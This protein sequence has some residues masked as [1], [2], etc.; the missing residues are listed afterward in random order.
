MQA[1]ATPM[2]V[3]MEGSRHADETK[4]LALSANP[5][6]RLWLSQ[7][8]RGIQLRLSQGVL[9]PG[10]E[11][12]RCPCATALLLPVSWRIPEFPWTSLLAHDKTPKEAVRRHLPKEAGPP[13][14]G[15]GLSGRHAG[16]RDSRQVATLFL[17][18]PAQT[19]DS[20]SP[21]CPPVRP[22]TNNAVYFGSLRTLR[23]NLDHR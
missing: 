15:D 13:Q 22:S 9:L 5:A 8:I 12:R 10:G 23:E 14:R 4:V 11:A 21:V 20:R 16:T 3:L 19:S 7:A 1:F 18:F 2:V 6:I 17:S